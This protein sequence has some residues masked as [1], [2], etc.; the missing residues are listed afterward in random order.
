MNAQEN[1]CDK[2]GR[3]SAEDEQMMGFP[4]I[5]P[6]K[7]VRAISSEDTILH[8]SERHESRE[9]DPR[10]LPQIFPRYNAASS[11]RIQYIHFSFHPLAAQR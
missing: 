6:S 5:M 11:I 10:I 2:A 4:S 7:A 8:A 9:N 3:L 1:G